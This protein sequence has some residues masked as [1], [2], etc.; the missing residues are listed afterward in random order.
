MKIK[1]T[2]PF[3]SGRA[4]CES[5]QEEEKKADL[6]RKEESKT[7]KIEFKYTTPL[8]KGYEEIEYLKT[9]TPEKIQLEDEVDE[10]E[11]DLIKVE[12]VVSGNSAFQ[13]TAVPSLELVESKNSSIFH[14]EKMIVK[15]LGVLSKGKKK[16]L[17][18]NNCTFNF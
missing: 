18:S 6:E 1:T 15:K 16:P 5:S 11:K 7:E 17:V 13:A 8:K 2:I 14:L 9:V 3:F 12:R 10:E 4:H